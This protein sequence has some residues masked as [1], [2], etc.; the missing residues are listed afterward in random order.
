M[1]KDQ[2]NQFDATA[3]NNTDIEGINTSET[4]V[5]SA[6]NNSIR[7]MMSLLKKQEVGTHAMTSPDINGGTID[8]TVI[9]GSSSAAGNFSEVVVSGTGNKVIQITSTDALATMEIGG[10]TG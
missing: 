9:G 3:G 10:T 2:I 4:M 5:P 6:V 7:S 1:S 8:G